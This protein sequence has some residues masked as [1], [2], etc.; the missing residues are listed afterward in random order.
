MTTTWKTRKKATERHKLLKIGLA[1]LTF[2]F[3]ILVGLWW[4]DKQSTVNQLTY[5]L[6]RTKAD[7]EKAKFELEMTSRVSDIRNNIEATFLKILDL[8]RKHS[9][10]VEAADKR[11]RKEDRDKTKREIETIWKYE[12]PPL[13]DNL[14]QLETM[15]A[16]LE[17][18]EPRNFDLPGMEP[19]T[20]NIIRR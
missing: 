20:P 17:N 11:S 5:D 12:F 7:L 19:F 9:T 6:V 16:N 15:L 1:V 14:I 8:Y 18:R 3:G 10:L 4:N 13:K 2:I